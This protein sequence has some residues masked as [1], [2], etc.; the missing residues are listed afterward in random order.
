MK[1]WWKVLQIL[2]FKQLKS[3][4]LNIWLIGFCTQTLQSS[5]ILYI[6]LMLLDFPL[7][8]QV[9]HIMFY[10][11]SV[12][13]YWTAK[14]RKHTHTHTH[15]Q[16]QQHQQQQNDKYSYVFLCMMIIIIIIFI[17]LA[18]RSI[19]WFFSFNF[20]SQ[21]FSFTWFRPTLVND[22]SFSNSVVHFSASNCSQQSFE[23][24]IIA[25]NSSDDQSI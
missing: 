24:N 10:Q 21:T 5:I 14:S 4:S 6:N 16:Q 13:C 1:L 22:H 15:T 12:L 9:S 2:R 11:N 19:S 18:Y 23:C 25:L 20:I 8:I 3:Q 7:L 17:C